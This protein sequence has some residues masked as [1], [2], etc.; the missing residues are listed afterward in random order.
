MTAP[1][2]V[3]IDFETYSAGVGRPAYPPEPVG[4]ALKWPDQ[5]SKYY[6]WGHATENNCQKFEAQRELFAAW[7]SGLPLLMHNA[8]FDLEVAA[9]HMGFDRPLH[10]TGWRS[11]A[12]ENWHDTRFLA[13]LCDPHAISHGL[14]DLAARYLNWPADEKDELAVWAW[15][16]RSRLYEVTG[17]KVTRTKKNDVVMA[18]NAMEFVPYMPGVLVGRYACGDV[19]RTAALFKLFYEYVEET[20]MLAA[21]DREREL[22]PIL[23]E[24]ERVGIRV[25]LARLDR[26]IQLY[27]RAMD[28][29]EN[30]LRV[31][32]G[33][34]GLNFDAD[35]DYARA[36]IRAGVVPEAAFARTEKRGD[37]K[38]G[39]DS[40]TPDMFTDPG[41]AQAV[42]Y[43]NRLKTCLSMFME[44]WLEQGQRRKGYVSTSW[45]Q[46]RGSEGGTRT[47][48]PSTSGEFNL[49]NLAKSFDGRPDGYVHPAFLG[50]PELP[51][52][53]RYML[54]DEGHVWLRRDFAGQE[55]RVFAHYEDGDL[56]RAYLENPALDPHSWVRDVMVRLIPSLA[57]VD[58]KKL[59]T[60]VKI[61]NFQSI[62]GGGVSAIQRGLNVSRAEAEEFKRFHEQ[63][64]PGRKKLND[65]ILRLVR[66]GEPIR[67]WGGRIY[68]PE[69]PR[70][71]DGR[72]MTWEYKL[73]NYL[74]QGSAADITKQSI[75]DWYNHPDRNARFLVSVY[76]ENDISAPEDD[77]VRQMRILREC[78]CAPRLDVPMLSDG[79]RGPS[80]G[81][82][83][84]CE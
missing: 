41:V 26:D 80:W 44:K 61:T 38:V 1:A 5:P 46:T 77:E 13:F 9:V 76:D 24:N 29:V 63:A 20:S 79:E 40:L 47:G 53:R 2:V 69:E 58:Q 64:L 32:L 50:L 59:R 7:N 75:I 66:S 17:V 15:E 52:V 71:V 45:N 19:D 68:F 84:E 42:G 74:V 33:D 62:Y 35:Q 51:L 6:A 3:T 18:G 78:M 48:R 49:L 70:V 39:K 37:Y 56:M 14:K 22:M 65:D 36:L 21:Y 8:K 54:P 60:K 12:C 4:L 43:R 23:L 57:T 83:E 16:H 67:T 34:P 28:H 55:L 27:R 82:L 25:D 11:R 10:E 31:R 73:I 72:L 30:A 81:E